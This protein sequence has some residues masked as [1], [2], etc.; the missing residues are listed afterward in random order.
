MHLRKD[1]AAQEKARG[2]HRVAQQQTQVASQAAEQAAHHALHART[3]A[4]DPRLLSA[5]D[6]VVQALAQAQVAVTVNNP[7]A[8]GIADLVRLQTILIEASL[9]PLVRGLTASIEHEKDNAQHLQEALASLKLIEERGVGPGT[10]G[11]GSAATE[12]YR[13]FKPKARGTRSDEK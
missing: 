1:A 11:A 10:A 13:P 5:L 8:Q 7:P 4:A 12:I 6:G 2:Q 9:L 3:V